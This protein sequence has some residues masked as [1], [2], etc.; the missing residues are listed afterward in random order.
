M[1]PAQTKAKKTKGRQ[2]PFWSHN[3]DVIDKAVAMTD[4]SRSAWID[5]VTTA[6]AKK[7]VGRKRSKR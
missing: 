4:L 2:I 6:A 5:K 1:A 3:E 7:A